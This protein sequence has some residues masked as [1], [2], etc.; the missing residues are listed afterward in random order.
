M[1]RSNIVHITLLPFYALFGVV[2]MYNVIWGGSLLS[3]IQIVI[4]IICLY[5]ITLMVIII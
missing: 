3:S 4:I 5:P 1:Y 2:Y